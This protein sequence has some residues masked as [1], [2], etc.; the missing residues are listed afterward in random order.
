MTASLPGEHLGTALGRG[1][2]GDDDHRERTPAPLAGAELGH[3]RL[4]PERDFRDEDDVAATREPSVERDPPGFAA[5]HLEQHDA[6]MAF[7]GA[8]QAVERPACRLQGSG[9]PERVLGPEKVVVDRL[10]HTDDRDP[11]LPP[12]PFGDR[13]RAV[14]ADHDQ[15]V[16]PQLVEVLLGRGGGVHQLLDPVR[17]AKGVA[18]RVPAVA[19]AQ[20]RAAPH[21]QARDVCERHLADLHLDESDEPVED[22]RHAHP[23]CHLA[24]P[25]DRA[26]Y[27]VQAGR[28]ATPGKNSDA[29]HC[30]HHPSSRP[31]CTSSMPA[32]R[33]NSLMR[34]SR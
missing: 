11:E 29:S 13:Q 19:R 31:R 14:A 27:G 12:E 9:E 15:A 1:A 16:E 34:S 25:H 28:I 32:S 10:G 6:V 2:L 8:V 23:V 33:A 22:P 17:A 26:D 5:H 3:Q 20:D 24:R 30:A 7:G 4:E 21:Q 18:E